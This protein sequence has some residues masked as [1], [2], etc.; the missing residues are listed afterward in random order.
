MKPRGIANRAIG[1]GESRRL[2]ADGFL[3]STFTLPIDDARAK[4]AKSFESI[5]L[6]VT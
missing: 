4:G 6:V 1:V 5:L 2:D 3:R